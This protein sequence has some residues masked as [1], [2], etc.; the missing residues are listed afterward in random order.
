MTEADF[1]IVLVVGAMAGFGLAWAADR[2][3][4]LARPAVEREKKEKAEA[5]LSALRSRDRAIA[6]ELRGVSDNIAGDAELPSVQRL[7]SDDLVALA[8]R[9]DVSEEG[10]PSEPCPCST[11]GGTGR[12]GANP[13]KPVCPDCRQET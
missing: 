2:F 12:I 8:D 13:Y 5:E 9:L 7:Y 4:R 11:C 6:E 1:L 10:D 3:S